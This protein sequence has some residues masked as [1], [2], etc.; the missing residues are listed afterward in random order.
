MAALGCTNPIS[1]PDFFF[2]IP[3]VCNI[4]SGKFSQPMLSKFSCLL[5]SKTLVLFWTLS[6]GCISDEMDIDARVPLELAGMGGG[7]GGGRR[8]S[9][10]SF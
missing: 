7:G 5:L 2:E 9:R 1:Q 3:L 8:E 6:S 10:I 4:I